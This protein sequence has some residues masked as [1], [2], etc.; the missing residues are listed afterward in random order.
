MLPV[1]FCCQGCQTIHVAQPL[2][3][4]L[5][6]NGDDEQMSFW[7]GLTERK[8]ACNDE[9]FHAL[10]LYF[11]GSDPAH[12]YAGRVQELRR[13]G[14]LPAGFDGSADEA[15]RRGTLAVALVKAMKIQGGWALTLLGPTPR[16][17]TRELQYDNLYPPSSPEQTFTGNELVGIIGR[18]ED[19]QRGDSSNL[20]ATELPGGSPGVRTR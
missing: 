17:A 14:M 9:A 8:V 2:T 16:Y 19:Y 18:V 15:V 3:T 6:G 13:R 5:G 10:L 4:K 20:P 7:H 12:D 1:L 11:D